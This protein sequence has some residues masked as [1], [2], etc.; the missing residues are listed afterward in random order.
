MSAAGGAATFVVGSRN[1]GPQIWYR[2]NTA[3]ESHATLG[4]GNGTVLVAGDQLTA[5]YNGPWY[6]A[7][8]GGSKG[9]PRSAVIWY[10]DPP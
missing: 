6:Q 9:S 7:L 2:N 3:W 4:Y 10:L 1:G 5:V 8:V